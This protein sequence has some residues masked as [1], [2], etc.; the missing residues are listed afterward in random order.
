MGMGMGGEL[1]QRDS[2]S[3]QATATGPSD[4]FARPSAYCTLS[5]DG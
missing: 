5:S 3:T 4:Y 1:S 2:G